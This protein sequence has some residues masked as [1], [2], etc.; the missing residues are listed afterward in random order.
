MVI[1]IKRIYY[2]ILGVIMT[3]C[4]IV[5]TLLSFNLLTIDYTFLEYLKY[6]ITHWECLQLIIG[7]ILVIYNLKKLT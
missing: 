5:M 3:V 1:D 7:L 6:F 4:G 2:L